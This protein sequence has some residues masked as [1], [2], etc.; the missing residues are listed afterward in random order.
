MAAAGTRLQGAP[1][2]RRQRTGKLQFNG[3]KGSIE[4]AF[5]TDNTTTKT[6]TLA[7][8]VDINV[9]ATQIDARLNLKMEGGQMKG[10]TFFLGVGF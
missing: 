10:I 7:I 1:R 8:N 6:V 5:T 3:N 9:G 2:H 4:W